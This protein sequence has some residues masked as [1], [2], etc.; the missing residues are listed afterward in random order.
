NRAAENSRSE[1]HR[2]RHES[3]TRALPSSRRKFRIPCVRRWYPTERPAWPAPMTSTSTS[4][5]WRRP[6]RGRGSSVSSACPSSTTTGELPPADSSLRMIILRV[7]STRR[8]VRARTGRPRRENPAFSWGVRM[9]DFPHGTSSHQL[10]GEGVRRRCRPRRNPELEED[11]AH[12]TVDRLLAQEQLAGDDL[13]G[14]ARG[15][16]AENLQF[17]RGQPVGT[18]APVLDRWRRKLGEVRPGPELLE[19]LARGGELQSR[20]VLVAEGAAGETG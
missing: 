10:V 2:C 12:V 4:V 18:L 16:Q 9:G 19:H 1:S 6:L 11:V 13:V 17:A 15:D 14:L 20:P 5:S 7:E 3:P 8:D